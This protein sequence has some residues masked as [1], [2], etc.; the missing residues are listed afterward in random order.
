MKMITIVFMQNTSQHLYPHIHNLNF[1]YLLKFWS[2]KEIGDS[3]DDHTSHIG[4]WLFVCINRPIIYSKLSIQ[5]VTFISTQN[6]IQKMHLTHIGKTNNLKSWHQFFIFKNWVDCL[7]F[8]KAYD[9]YLDLFGEKII[10]PP[11]GWLEDV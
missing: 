10:S 1:E 4:I 9:V 3:P 2:P 8:L 7:I 11:G 5:C 6:N